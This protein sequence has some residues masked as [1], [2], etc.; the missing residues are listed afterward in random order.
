MGRKQSDTKT[1]ATNDEHTAEPTADEPSSTTT[2]T[3]RD[4]AEHPALPASADCTGSVTKTAVRR[5]RKI[6][7][8][9]KKC[10]VMY[11]NIRGLKS[12]VESLKEIL[13][14]ENPE[15][16]GLTE[17]MLDEADVI[18]IEGYTVHRNDR[19]G[20]GGG[21]LLAVK[22]DLKGLIVQE[23]KDS[24]EGESLWMSMG[25]TKMNLRM[26]IVYNPQESRT[27]K[28]KLKK[29][30]QSMEREVK[31]AK[32][33]KQSVLLM[34]D[35]NCKVGDA[36]NGNKGEVSNGGRMLLEMMNRNNLTMANGTKTCKGLW[37]R[38][39]GMERSVLDYII[40]DDNQIKH[41]QG[42][43]IV[44]EKKMAPY[45]RI[46]ENGVSR[47]IHSDHNT[48]MLKID[49]LMED[50]DAVNTRQRKTMDNRAYVQFR[51]L[52]NEEK[53]S[54]I[55]EEGFDIQ[56]TYDKWNET[57][58][59]I[60]KRC[61]VK[62]K[63]PQEGKRL[64]SLRDAKKSIRHQLR[65][66]TRESPQRELTEKRLWQITKYIDGEKIEQEKRNVQK[67]V[68]CITTSEERGVNENA[69]WKFKRRTEKRKI[70][71]RTAM[72]NSSGETTENEEEIKCIYMEFYKTLLATTKATSPEESEAERD[73]NKTFRTIE[74]I[75]L[76]QDPIVIKEEH[77]QKVLKKLKRRKA[78]DRQ[79]W[80]NELILEGGE[81]MNK[82]IQ[83][84]FN[85]IVQSQKVPD[86]CIVLYCIVLYCIVL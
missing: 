2:T 1:N 30:Y 29:V 32:E 75:A 25:N 81:E 40:L 39:C 47:M 23:C 84:M 85:A 9:L 43:V 64:R 36:I 18:D 45:R 17:T 6:Q 60:K 63:K 5:S 82:S 16:V 21:V 12:K 14:D 34:G 22:I 48:M 54:Q 77:L 61:E 3:S 51:K 7:N 20:I 70:E 46:I 38:Q 58:M 73:V 80:T 69:F 52:V 56:E 11:I 49:L 15:I 65:C 10:K 27:K 71:Q 28:N 24:E 41:V 4:T 50:R 19:N 76:Q 37:T 72:V 78:G 83:L 31:K 57:V 67:A 79:E 55:W 74:T 26:G 42:L 13:L 68:D 66:I 59:N 62:N 35:F 44:E 33:K 8:K 53:V 86:Q